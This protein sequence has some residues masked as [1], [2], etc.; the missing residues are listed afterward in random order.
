MQ[1]YLQVFLALL[2]AH[3]LGDF[4]LQT[5]GMV[6]GKTAMRVSAYL[7]HGFVHLLI[8]IAALASFTELPLSGPSTLIALAILVPGHLALDLGKSTLVRALP[9]SDGALL[10]TADQAMH[11][12]IVALVTAVA[13]QAPP[14][15]AALYGLWMVYRDTFLVA[16]L[17]IA[18]TV[19]P[20][21]YLIRYMLKPLSD[22]LGV[23]R[24]RA[25]GRESLEGLS[26]A[27]LYLGWLERGLL[28]I[29]FAI[30]S[31]TAVGLI[32]GAKSVARFPEFRSRAFAEY[33]LIGTLISVAIAAVGGSVLHLALDALAG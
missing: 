28:V 1:A 5:R 16:A 3:L 31:F 19:F 2:F 21:G 17:V 25:T 12:L 8:S 33:F 11:V 20:A 23:D 29:A 7:S 6:L 27:G 9:A 14:P 4:P 30:G 24:E 22:Q 18:A 10:Y 32:I 26:N 13:V 15:V